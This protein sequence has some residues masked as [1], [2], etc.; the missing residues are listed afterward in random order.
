VALLSQDRQQEGAFTC[1]L[2][3]SEIAIVFCTIHNN[4]TMKDYFSMLKSSVPPQCTEGL[5]IR[6]QPNTYIEKPELFR[7]ALHLVKERGQLNKGYNTQEVWEIQPKFA[8][9]YCVVSGLCDKPHWQDFPSNQSIIKELVMCKTKQ[10]HLRSF[11]ASRGPNLIPGV[12]LSITEQDA[13]FKT[14]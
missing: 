13:L 5:L 11:S 7:T 12:L 4:I 3:P 8:D 14:S 2:L 1:T 6:V 10:S 9:V